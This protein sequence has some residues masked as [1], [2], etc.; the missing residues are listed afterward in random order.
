MIGSITESFTNN[1]IAE[2]RYRQQ[3]NTAN[4]TAP[5]TP[6]AVRMRLAGKIE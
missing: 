6:A 3:V 5:A 2:D 1:L 4:I